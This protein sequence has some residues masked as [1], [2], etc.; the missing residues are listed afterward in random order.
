MLGSV[1]A[2]SEA[3]NGLRPAENRHDTYEAGTALLAPLQLIDFQVIPF[4][5]DEISGVFGSKRRDNAGIYD[6]ALGDLLEDCK[7]HRPNKKPSND[8]YPTAMPS[9]VRLSDQRPLA[10]PAPRPIY[11]R[12]MKS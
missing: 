11:D 1:R 4:A 10:S 12:S 3:A 6:S 9:M 5:E 8:E 7:T 2:R